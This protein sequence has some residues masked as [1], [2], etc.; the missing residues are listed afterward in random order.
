MSHVTQP[1][2]GIGAV[3]FHDNAVLL[4]KRKNPPCANEWAI[5]GGR[6]L[7]GETLQQAAEREILEETGVKIKAG[8]P[9]YSFDLID[10]DKQGNLLFHYVIID[11]EAGYLEGEPQADDDALEAAWVDRQ[12]ATTMNINH[13]TKELLRSLYDFDF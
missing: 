1:V 13:T 12:Q 5:P 2:V 8:Q 9:V 3:V 4:V 10:K 11:L 6:I 7:P